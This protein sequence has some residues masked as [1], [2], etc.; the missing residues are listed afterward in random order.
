MIGRLVPSNLGGSIS[1]AQATWMKL[2][3]AL[4][5]VPAIEIGTT[6]KRPAASSKNEG[7]FYYG[8]DTSKLYLS[9]ANAWKEV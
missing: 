2:I 4:A 3:S 9:V 8:T 1:Q 7:D 6:A 5:R